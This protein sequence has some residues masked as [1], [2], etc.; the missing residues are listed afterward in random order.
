MYTSVMVREIK[1]R[2]F[3]SLSVVM[4][5]D[6]TQATVEAKAIKYAGC[7]A[8]LVFVATLLLYAGR[9]M[10]LYGNGAIAVYAGWLATLAVIVGFLCASARDERSLLKKMNRSKLA[11]AH[12]IYANISLMAAFSVVSLLV[13]VAVCYLLQESFKGLRFDAT[14]AA[15]FT[16]L[17][18]A[19]VAYAVYLVSANMSANTVSNLLALFLLSAVF[20]SMLTADNA[21]WWEYHFSSLGGGERSFSAS[22]FNVGLVLGGG[23]L[24]A[25]ADFIASDFSRLRAKNKVYAK[26]R[27]AFV[28]TSIALI[29]VL[30]AFVGLF[31]YD[32]SPLIHNIA[33]G[34]M[35]IVFVVLVLTLPLFVPTLSRSFYVLS[36]ALM[37]AVVVAYILFETVGY[38]N[39][40]AFELIAAGLIFSWLAVFV[41]QLA[42]EIV[43]EGAL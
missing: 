24:V 43:E 1:T 10:P 25:L 42:S 11:L 6:D 34:G 13:T 26:Y 33:A 3:H 17:L 31:A 36:Y 14:T 16:A 12:D 30:L 18:V 29:G 22:V 40:T 21:Q 8:I 19:V 20:M 15:G 32:T 37:A 28:G 38:L 41:R 9:G 27:T 2:L 39:L 23:I 35:A 4:R 7:S 5:E